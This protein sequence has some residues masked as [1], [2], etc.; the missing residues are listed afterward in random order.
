LLGVCI[1]FVNVRVLN[2]ENIAPGNELEVVSSKDDFEAPT[3]AVF[4]GAVILSLDGPLRI[5][6]AMCCSDDPIGANNSSTT[7]NELAIGRFIP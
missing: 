1:V 7:Y 6:Q 4:P 2:L 5:P 3:A